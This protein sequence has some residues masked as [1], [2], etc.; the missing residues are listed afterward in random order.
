MLK[1]T[2]LNKEGDY[3]VGYVFSMEKPV[4]VGSGEGSD[5]LLDHESVGSV[6]A[7]FAKQGSDIGLVHLGAPTGTFLNKEALSPGQW[8]KISNNDEIRFGEVVVRVELD[9]PNSAVIEEV[10]LDPEL[11][12]E[13]LHL[14]SSLTQ[15]AYEEMLFQRIWSGKQQTTVLNIKRSD[16]PKYERWAKKYQLRGL[17]APNDKGERIDLLMYKESRVRELVES[18]EKIRSISNVT[19][20][21]FMAMLFQW[22]EKFIN[23]ILREAQERK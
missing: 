21:W 10:N 16:L 12:K 20:A 9:E 19:S 6:H 1:V 17:T 4:K 8:L 3:S 2:V 23:D 7:I 18:W 11:V 15:L 5:L 22:P 13:L 14:G